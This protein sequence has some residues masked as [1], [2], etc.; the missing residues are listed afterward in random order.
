MDIL[1]QSINYT[2]FGMSLLELI[3]V[4]F[5]FTSILLAVKEKIWTFP[6]AIVGSLLF[7]Y[8]FFDHRVYSSAVLQLVFLSFNLFGWWKWTHPKA[9]EA[10]ADKT[11]AV[12]ILSWKG[13]SITL[14]ISIVLYVGLV[15]IMSHLHLWLPAIFPSKANSVWIDTFILAASL[16]GQYLMAIKKLENW[17]FWIAVD[18][19]AAPFYFFTV[20][21]ATG[22]MY[23]AFIF[24]GFM[25]FLNWKKS[26]HQTI[27]H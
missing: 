3:A 14:L 4:V 27:H 11:L 17:V 5:T 1:S 6:L 8:L 7:L 15:F 2:L 25:G 12:S 23:L 10:K 22:I 9:D 19:I 18:V 16:T 26:Y 21:Y 13:R 24:T 20:G